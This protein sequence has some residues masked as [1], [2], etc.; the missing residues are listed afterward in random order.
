MLRKKEQFHRIALWN[1]AKLL[2]RKLSEIYNKEFADSSIINHTESDIRFTSIPYEK[3]IQFAIY[4]NYL[5]RDIIPHKRYIRARLILCFQS[6]DK[7]VSTSICLGTVRTA[8][9]Y[10]AS[11]V[12]TIY[13]KIGLTWTIFYSSYHIDCIIITSNAKYY[14]L[15]K[16]PRWYISNTSFRTLSLSEKTFWFTGY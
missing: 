16:R 12:D 7:L 8:F 1:I 4:Q 5:I 2:D 6:S 3:L 13:L 10:C 14:F 15:S 11:L 9:V